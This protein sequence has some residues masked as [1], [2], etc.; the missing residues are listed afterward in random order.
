MITKHRFSLFCL[1]LGIVFIVIAMRGK[2]PPAQNPDP[3]H[4]HADFAVWIDG[5]Q[6]DFSNNEFMSGSTDE[7]DPDHT[8]L[9]QYLHLHDN[10]GH[11]IHR[12]KPG[13]K[14]GEF[15]ASIGVTT[16]K[17]G[18]NAC[19]HIPNR[20]V[21]CEDEAMH[22]NWTM[23]VNGER[24]SMDFEFVFTDTDRIL[25]TNATDETEIAKQLG[26]LTDDAC[27]YSRTCPERGEPPAENCIADPT[28]PCV[29]Q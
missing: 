9:N 6:I 11:V 1:V 23:I 24:Q 14:L 26:V 25:I 22:K 7:E 28:V 15:F 19:L 27:R 2:T 5:S 17:N 21:S 4:T 12:H 20:A 3:N 13:L 29:V 16:S 8:R 18:L 10:I